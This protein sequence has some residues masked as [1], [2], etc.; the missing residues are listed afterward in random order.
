MALARALAGEEASGWEGLGLLS[1]SSIS[2]IVNA[3][4]TSFCQLYGS[5]GRAALLLVVRRELPVPD[6]PDLTD[7]SE[8][9][10]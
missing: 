7:D 6:G 3:A 2:D 10:E 4:L 9:I 1:G 5:D 8:D